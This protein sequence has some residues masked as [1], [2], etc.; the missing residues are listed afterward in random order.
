MIAVLAFYLNCGVVLVAAAIALLGARSVRESLAYFLVS[1]FALVGVLVSIGAT[2]VAIAQLLFCTSLGLVYFFASGTIGEA[3]RKQPD[4]R[5][6]GSWH[7]LV[8]ALGVAG[9]CTMASLL[10]EVAPAATPSRVSEMASTGVPPGSFERIGIEL[11]VRDGLALL[12]MGLV[13]V[14]SAVGAGFL[15][16]RERR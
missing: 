5:D 9:A 6:P 11:I 3:S 16:S 10:F 14:A 2:V 8:V 7:W 4:D 13:L 12:A 15:A 1:L